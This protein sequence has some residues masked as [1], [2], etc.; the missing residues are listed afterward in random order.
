MKKISS[1]IILMAISIVF[2]TALII[3]TFVGIQNYNTNTNMISTLDKTIRDNFDNEINYQVQNALSMLDGVNK[4]FENGEITIEEAKKQ[5]AD[6]LRGLK[7]GKDG[8]F[9]ADTENGVNIVLNGTATEGTNR[10]E[11][12]DA[13]GKFLIKEIIS[14]GMNENGGFSDYAFPKKGETIPLPKRSFSQ[15]FKP[16]NWII[17]TGNYTDDIDTVVS[18]KEKEL[19]DS[20]INGL[21]IMVGILIL[22]IIVS[23]GIAYYFSKKITKPILLIT[24]LVDKTAR[25][26]L[27]YD[28][29]FE[30]INKYKDETG[31]IGI[32][33]INLRK[34]LRNIVD[35]IKSDSTEILKLANTLSSATG[36]TVISINTI[37]QTLEELSKGSVSQATDA[38]GG[39]ESLS[40]LSD[41][42][43][44]SAKS[45]DMVKEYSHEVKDVNLTS[46][47]TFKSLK[48]KL[49]E[50]NS[51]TK[52]V[53]NNIGTLLEKSASIGKIV[54]SIQGIA[55]QT[56]LLAL[57][58][59][60]EAARAGETGKG[61]A[62]VADEVRK[63]SE[64]TDISAKEIGTV[65]KEIQNEI[66]KAKA[67]MNIGE[68]L[69]NEVN[70]AM[71]DTDKSFNVIEV[72]INNTIMKINELSKNIE[73]VNQDKNGIVHSIESIS[74]VSEETAAATE[75]VSASM[76]EQM[77][78]MDSIASDS[79]EL[80]DI[81]NRLGKLVDKIQL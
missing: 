24:E 48:V 70:S 7:F 36:E 11:S 26:D 71:E 1:K 46:K 63:L 56:N 19:Q 9:W 75:E 10:F 57:N 31:K 28:S 80:K 67:S 66:E 22:L 37:N 41:E 21:V 77:V 58:A 43:E 23:S 61:F 42:I 20:F 51:A 78:S 64:E 34:E 30:I 18:E 13:N 60:I 44:L 12:K 72:T 25:F 40:S 32:S 50:N 69:G 16:F 6:Q 8:Y 76:Q 81:A 54:S 73:K 33:V 29:S 39:A 53:S 74:A 52:E 47:D 14:Q 65:I 17:G 38:Q 5:G 79:D 45:S 27:V 4:R 49:E 15:E 62:V 2:C 59:A 55:A 68:N 35:F 3:G